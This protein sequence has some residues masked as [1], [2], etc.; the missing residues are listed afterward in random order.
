MDPLTNLRP[1]RR[2]DTD[3]ARFAAIGPEMA[4]IGHRSELTKGL[5]LTIVDGRIAVWTAPDPCEDE[6]EQ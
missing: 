6:V 4:E 3:P 5:S 2:L 1:E